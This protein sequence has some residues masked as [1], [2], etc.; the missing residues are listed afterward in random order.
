MNMV[1]LSDGG[2][3]THVMDILLSIRKIFLHEVRTVGTEQTAI[4]S[5]L[6]PRF[7]PQARLR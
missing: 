4:Q 2:L 3:D 6:G 1:W 7:L 5:F